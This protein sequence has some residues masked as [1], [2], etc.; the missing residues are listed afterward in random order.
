MLLIPTYLA[1]SPIHG[2]GV[3]TAEPLPA[4][5]KIWEFTPDV[6]WRLTPDDLASFPEPYQ[7]K[8]RSWCYLDDDG[9]YVLCGDNARF[10]N[11]TDNPNCDDPEGIFTVTNRLIPAGEELTCDY[12]SFDRE[13]ILNGLGFTKA[14]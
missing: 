11:H 4:G 13:S 7:S 12:R 14:G 8:M 1:A 6:D 5:K 2:V 3:F 10:M 9:R